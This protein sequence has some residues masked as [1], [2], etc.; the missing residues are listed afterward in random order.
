MRCIPSPISTTAGNRI[1]SNLADPDNVT[2]LAESLV[3]EVG[4][5]GRHQLEPHS[6]LY[7]HMLVGFGIAT[8]QI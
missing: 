2:R 8:Q 4:L 6:R 7:A 5:D 3:K 1:I